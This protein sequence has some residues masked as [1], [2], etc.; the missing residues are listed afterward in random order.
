MPESYNRRE[1]L[2]YSAIA[3]GS[4]EA[5]RPVDATPPAETTVQQVMDLIVARCAGKPL[6]QTVDTLKTGVASQKVQGIATTFMA[7]REVIEKAIQA[8]ANL[9]ITHE[10]TFWGHTDDTGWLANDP[11]YLSKRR[12][13]DENRIAILRC[14]DYWHTLRPDP[15]VAG[16][17][18]ELG[19][20]KY[21]DAQARNLCT[22]PSTP[23]LELARFFK[24]RLGI[25]AVQVVGNETMPCRRVALLVG[26][27]PGR[28]Q[29]GLLGQPDIDVVVTGDINEWE[30]CE[31]ARD[32]GRGGLNKGFL[33]LGHA[34]SEEPGMRYL[35]EWLRPLLPGTKIT[36]IPASSP[37]RLA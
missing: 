7:T 37:F 3:L 8:G 19:W 30:G 18:R 22:I 13:I 24:Q 26:A 1:F 27:S 2:K 6:A 14:H 29:I 15:V 34:A 32:A 12:L 4:A 35:A 36:H 33:V 20:E 28:T 23:L 11:V 16:L 9:V 17:Q 21:A 5:V 31:Y 25:G 10:P